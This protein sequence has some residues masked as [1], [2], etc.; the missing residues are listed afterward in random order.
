MQSQIYLTWGECALVFLLQLEL[1]KPCHRPRSGNNEQR[2]ERWTTFDVHMRQTTEAAGLGPAVSPSLSFA[3]VCLL[4][5]PS[6]TFRDPSLSIIHFAFGTQSTQYQILGQMDGHSYADSLL[7]VAKCT[8]KSHFPKLPLR[9]F[10]YSKPGKFSTD[11]EVNKS[12]TMQEFYSIPNG[13]GIF[14]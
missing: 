6:P 7:P 2:M 14:F 8:W 3:D 10:K 9:H 4:C 1:R 5:L 11:S 13:K 12:S